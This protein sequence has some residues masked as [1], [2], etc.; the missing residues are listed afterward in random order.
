MIKE[1]FNP[2]GGFSY[3][4]GKSQT[5]Y[6]GVPISNGESVSDIHGTCLLTWA[7]VMILEILENNWVNWKVIRP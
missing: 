1:H 2:D 3:N 4:I 6:Y 5:S 7:V